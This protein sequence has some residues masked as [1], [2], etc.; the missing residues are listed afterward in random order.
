MYLANICTLYLRHIFM[1][2]IHFTA[3]DDERQTFQ[4]LRFLLIFLFLRRKYT[5]PAALSHGNAIYLT[6]Q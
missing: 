2:L 6:D 4:E 5:D 1:I 3:K